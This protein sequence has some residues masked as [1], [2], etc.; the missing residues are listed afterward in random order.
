MN[1]PMLRVAYLGIFTALGLILSYVES[2]FPVF[3][4]IPGVKLGLANLVT[5]LLLYGCS[6]KE[7][8][9]VSLV[10]I[11][12]AGF[13]FGNLMGIVFGLCGGLLSLLVM[14]LIKRT[15]LFS[16]VGVSV[17]G[18]FSHN[19]GQLL[20]A[21]FVV[22]LPQLVYYIPVLMVSG[23]LTGFLIGLTGYTLRKRLPPSLWDFIKGDK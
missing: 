22:R 9:L 21:A 4:G 15:G 8:L 12:A 14:V 6:A 16:M 13:L 19:L 1:R 20:V 18:G 2:L 23:I 10:R 5:V 7:A 3:A 11:L 17:A